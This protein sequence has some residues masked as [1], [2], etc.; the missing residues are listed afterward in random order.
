MESQKIKELSELG[1]ALALATILNFIKVY[2]LPQ[3][4]SVSLEMVP[5]FFIALRWGVK[6]GI[7]LGILYG[8]LQLILGAKIYYPLQAILDYP[9]AFGSLGVAGVIHNVFAE[10]DKSL[11]ELI[12]VSISILFAGSL[13]LIIHT[14][15]GVIFFAEYAPESQNPWF[16]SIGYN[17]SYMLPEIMIT[18]VIMIIL[19]RSSVDLI[20]LR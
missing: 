18:V 6:Q 13:R 9:L 12:L 1:I 2:E 15:S 4:G 7:T 14:V 11:K 8:S 10:I 5:I 19:L 17:L 3:G 16:Y 20:D